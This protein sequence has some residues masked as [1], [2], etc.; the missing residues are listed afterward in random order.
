MDASRVTWKVQT[1]S[2]HPVAGEKHLVPDDEWQVR[3]G[4]VVGFLASLDGKAFAVIV[5]DEDGRYKTVSIDDLSIDRDSTSATTPVP[6]AASD[7]APAP[8]P[9]NGDRLTRKG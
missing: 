5:D 8:A 6:V 1:F 9:K 3:C 7:T 4:S 2:P